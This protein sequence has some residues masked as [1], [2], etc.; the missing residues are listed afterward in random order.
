[1]KNPLF[2]KC[3]LLALL[4]ALLLIPLAMIE[5]TIDERT[6][7]RAGAIRAI[8]A[9]T[10]GE[11]SI[12]GPVLTVVVEEEFDEEK[13]D[14]NNGWS[15]KRT[16]RSKRLHTIETLPRLVH[17][18]GA[19]NVEKRAYGLHE[20]AVFELQGTVTG[21]FDTP[22][23]AALPT[24]GANAHLT[25]GKP[26][27]SMG[28]A[29]PRGVSGEPKI[30]LG[31]QTLS[32]RRTAHI[33]GAEKGFHGASDV[34]LK[35]Q[36]TSLPFKIDLRL[37]GT[38]SIG[39]VPLGEVSTAELRGNWPHP[40]FTGDFLPR[41]RELNK[42]GFAARWSTTGLASASEASAVRTQDAGFQVRLIDPVDVYR[43]AL[44]AVKYGVLFVVLSFAAF[45]T[46]EHLKTLPI[47][48]IQYMLVGLTQAVF[49]LLLTSLSEHISFSLAYLLA[50][51]ASITLIGVYL[52]SILRGWQRGLGFSSALVIL[53]ASLFGILR[54]EQNALL[55]GSLLLFVALAGLMLGT[56]RMDWYGLG[57][58]ATAA[59]PEGKV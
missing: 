17:L 44:R 19:L 7:H 25:W 34:A 15:K 49:F 29:D 18:D 22:T 40:S 10:A 26:T 30:E 51:S 6:A 56:R 47:H 41:S 20:T 46:F 58:P 32:P 31:G 8:A 54:S 48:P 53:Y 27:L 59:D 43:Q 2:L 3:A 12:V 35:G 1:M 9:S 37:A 5:R 21:T 28:I 24:L 36:S 57:Q 38:G 4:A 11:Q 52:A 55:L 39:F 50:A 13:G 33:K 42:D 14:D 45:F 16:L 23:A